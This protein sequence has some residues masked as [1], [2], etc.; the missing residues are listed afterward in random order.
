MHKSL[1]DNLFKGYNVYQKKKASNITPL[2]ERNKNVNNNK[3][4]YTP[5][6]Q[7]K[8]Q[9]QKILNAKRQEKQAKEG[10]VQK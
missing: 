3:P 8:E 1:A 2:R 9:V 5:Q 7:I 10:E 6:K 4:S